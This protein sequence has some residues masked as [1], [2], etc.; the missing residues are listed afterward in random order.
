MRRDLSR[1]MC[2]FPFEE[3]YF[4]DRG[5]SADYV[6]HP[7]TR[8]VKP[9]LRRDDFFAKHGLDGTRPLVTLLPGS[10]TGEVARHVPALVDAARRLN[11]RA[12]RNLVLAVPASFTKRVGCEFFRERIRGASIQVV[13]GETW[14]SLAH[15]D[16]AVAASGTVTIEAALLGTPMVTFYRVNRFSWSLGRHLVR[17]PFYTMVNLVAG[18]KVVPELMQEDAT[19]ECMAA[20][21]EALLE[22]DRL[23]DEMKRELA[24]VAAM[25]ATDAD[26]IERAAHIVSEYLK[27]GHESNGW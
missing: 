27:E 10:R 2:I 5:I 19:G 24:L 11:R 25:L 12:D 8:I 3:K 7:L 9:V 21:A 16:V 6:G 20:E 23:R 17:V 1:L 22:N 18:R 4:R 13:E 14:D 26:P 15:A